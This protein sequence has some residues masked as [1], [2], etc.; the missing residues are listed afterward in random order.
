MGDGTPKYS[1]D[2]ALLSL[3]FGKF[4]GLMLAYAGMAYVAE[5]MEVMLLSFVGPAVQLEWNLS[6]REESM[7]TSV[8]FVGMLFG[9]YTWGIVSD[10]YGRRVG[11]FTTALVTGGAGLLSS[12]SPNYVSLIIIRCVVGVG[13]GGGPVLSSWFLEF[14]PAPN[15][16]TW[17]VVFS[18]F[19]TLGTIL[20]ASLAWAVM[21]IL[22]WRWLLA[23]SSIPSF[24][25]LL[26]YTL[27]PE[28]P[29]FLCLNGRTNDSL[30]VLE[31]ISR[32]NEKPLP[33]GTLISDD[34]DEKC[35]LME[36]SHFLPATRPETRV[37][38]QIVDKMGAF[39]SFFMLFSPKLIKSTVLLWLVFFGNAFS[40]YGLIL[41]TS[42]LSNGNR[43]CTSTKLQS[44][45]I[46]HVNLYKNVLI[47]SCAEIPGLLLSAVMVDCVGRKF[48][49]SALFFLCCIFLL[50][51]VVSQPDTLT[52][53]L[54]FGAR[55]CITGTFTIVYIYAP[56]VYPTSIRTTGFGTASSVGRIGGMV[57]PVVAVGLVH[58]CQQTFAVILFE[59]VIFLSG[60][61]VIFFPLE[62]KGR[63]LRD[64]LST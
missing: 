42:E 60:I 2:E 64:T 18:V 8:V 12:F 6:S 54:L 41:L 26:F 52:T 32:I 38:K 17:M 11:F 3:G 16:G 29:R 31:K 55:I 25:L 45:V 24:V 15:R 61:A 20:E 37:T 4:Q 51:L 35:L 5:A 49:M 21:P 23:L 14:I 62:T 9:A 48:S 30:Q 43:A 63:P 53:I 40:Y 59:V 56:E 58:S 46:A 50:P 33:H 44:K 34:L 10:T 22:G 27:V 39:A 36:D 28:S 1:V 47:T 19:W 13:L 7:I 57:C